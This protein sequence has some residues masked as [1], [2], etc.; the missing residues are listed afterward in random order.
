MVEEA[1]RIYKK[2]Y[3]RV[4]R[5]RDKRYMLGLCVN[6]GKP[7]LPNKTRCEECAL[8]LKEANRKRIER[9]NKL[10]LCVFCAKN[11]QERGQLCNACYEKHKRKAYARKLALKKRIINLLGGKCKKCGYKK[12]YACLEFHHKHGKDKSEETISRM[13]DTEIMEKFELMC[14]RCHRELH[15]PNCILYED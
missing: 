4:K 12:N 15:R 5:Y 6:C 1:E 11:P 14:N 10:G 7:R 3:K 2:R 9:L 8:K 13:S